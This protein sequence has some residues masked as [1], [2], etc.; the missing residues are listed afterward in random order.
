MTWRIGICETAVLHGKA[1]AKCG[2]DRCGHQRSTHRVMMAV[3]VD[4]AAQFGVHARA[5]VD[6][7]VIVDTY[8]VLHLRQIALLGGV[9]SFAGW[10]ACSRL[11][12]V[13][14]AFR[15]ITG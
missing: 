4:T 9:R 6:D 2:I 8:A 11:E 7:L 15:A 3:L 1:A 13:I 14:H 12:L 10:R 5:V